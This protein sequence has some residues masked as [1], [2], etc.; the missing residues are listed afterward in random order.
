MIDE[1]NMRRC[2]NSGMPKG[3]NHETK[4]I[5][6]STKVMEPSS[7]ALSGV[8][9]PY[10]CRNAFYVEQT[11]IYSAPEAW[12]EPRNDHA[13]RFVVDNPG[14]GFVHAVTTAEIKDFLLQIEASLAGR[15]AELLDVIKLSGRTR[16]NGSQNLYGLQW[17]SAVYLYPFNESLREI[18]SYAPRNDQRIQTERYGGRWARTSNNQYEV[19]WTKSALRDFYLCEVLMHEIGHVLDQKNTGYR[20]REQFADAFATEH[21]Y[22]PWR[23]NQPQRVVA[24]RHH[25]KR[26]S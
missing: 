4:R 8:T 5:S 9:L 10:L 17:G 16:K 19:I 6:P 14:R 13:I 25:S 22:L 23:A 26:N 7:H 11:R 1:I 12:Y 2:Y 21:G 3:I 15:I 20:E 18:Y 24:K